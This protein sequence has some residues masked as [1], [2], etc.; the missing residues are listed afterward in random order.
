MSL[1]LVA[2]ESVEWNEFRIHAAFRL[3]IRTT[4]GCLGRLYMYHV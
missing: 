1:F 3:P 4:R 2:I